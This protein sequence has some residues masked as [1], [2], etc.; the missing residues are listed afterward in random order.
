MLQMKKNKV[1]DL[2]NEQKRF[3]RSLIK[4]LSGILVLGKKPKIKKFDNYTDALNHDMGHL[5]EDFMA[6]FIKIV[7]DLPQEK[8]NELKKKLL[9]LEEDWYKNNSYLT[10]DELLLNNSKDE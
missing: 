3:I 2:S 1:D 8:K 7:K 10:D 9:G 5:N 4:G 6:S